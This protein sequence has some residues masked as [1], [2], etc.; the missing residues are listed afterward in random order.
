MDADS[1][2]PRDGKHLEVL[3][4]T[5]LS[6]E[7][8]QRRNL[9]LDSFR[10]KIEENQEKIKLNK[11]LPYLVGNIIEAIQALIMATLETLN[12]LIAANGDKLRSAAYGAIIEELSTVIRISLHRLGKNSIQI[13][14]QNLG[15]INADF[16]YLEVKELCAST[17]TGDESENSNQ[18]DD[19]RE[20]DD[21]QGGR[22]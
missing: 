22:K 3:G 4:Y 17:T 12:A 18:E 5:I 8:L 2:S 19:D 20:D 21:S 7:E 16:K 1:R 15:K 9:E 6:W 13:S 11:Q 10:A 14:I